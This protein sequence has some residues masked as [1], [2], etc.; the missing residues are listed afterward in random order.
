MKKRAVAYAC[1]TALLI[2]AGGTGT[3]QVSSR[4]RIMRAVDASQPAAVRG[5][6]HPMARAQ[7][8]RGRTDTT[9]ALIA[10][11]TF[12][13]SLAQQA[14]MD[15]LLQQQQDRTSPNYHKWLTPAEFARRPPKSAAQ[16]ITP[17]VVRRTR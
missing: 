8:D 6:A 15:L 11:L 1:V 13:L 3:S 9:K 7:F 17:T 16:G 2:T 4:N 14:D 5:T 12:R 10:T